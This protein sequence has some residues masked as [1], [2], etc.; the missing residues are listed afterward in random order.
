MGIVLILE[1]LRYRY[2]VDVFLYIQGKR[3]DVHASAW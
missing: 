3:V 2:G 1:M